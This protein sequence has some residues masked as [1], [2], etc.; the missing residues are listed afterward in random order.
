MGHTSKS[1]DTFRKACEYRHLHTLYLKFAISSIE[2]HQPHESSSSLNGPYRST[3]VNM[4]ASYHL[5]LST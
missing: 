3:R 4:L 2:A 1:R 5:T